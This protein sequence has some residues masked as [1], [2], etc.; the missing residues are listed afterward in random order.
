MIPAES[1]GTF[2]YT[3]VIDTLGVIGLWRGWPEMFYQ[4]KRD[5]AWAW[6]WLDSFGI[7]KTE[8]NCVWYVRCGYIFVMVIVTAG[9]AFLYFNPHR[10]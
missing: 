7:Q 9:A 1:V 5:S 10:N 2:S 4:R 8:R 6:F 3:A